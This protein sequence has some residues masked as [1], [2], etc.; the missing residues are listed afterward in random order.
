MAWLNLLRAWLGVFVLL[1]GI[2]AL[3][4]NVDSTLIADGWSEITFDGK[5]PNRFVPDQSGGVA[6]KSEESVSLIQ[7]QLDVDLDETPFL[8]WRWQVAK[9][10]P[11][12]DLGI[13]GED[14]RSLALYVAFPFVTEEATAFERMRRAIVEKVAGKEAPGRVLTYVWGGSRER[15]EQVKSPYLGQ[16]GM[17]TILRPASTE[18]STWFEEIVDLKGDYLRTF[19]SKAPDPISIAIGADTDDTESMAE[20]VITNLNF[21]ARA[22]SS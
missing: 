15:G 20:G 14:D 19:G 1:L 22:D 4:M 3:A 17:I 12:T 7:R 5:T 16:S 13:K 9:A 6:V 21:K 11:A 2:P 8:S 10:A 18:A